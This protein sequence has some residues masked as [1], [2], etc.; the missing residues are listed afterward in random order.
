MSAPGSA[1][2]G[3]RTLPGHE[4]NRVAFRVF[5]ERHPLRLAGGSEG[6]VGV[7]VHGLR[8][9]SEANALGFQ[10]GDAGVEVVGPKVEDRVALRRAAGFEQHPCTVKV[11]EEQSGRIETCDEIGAD[12]VAVERLRG[13]RQ[14]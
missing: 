11:E 10:F 6:A 9:M 2:R 7:G 1:P 14:G 4:G 12:H 8:R 5:E 13:G 3:A